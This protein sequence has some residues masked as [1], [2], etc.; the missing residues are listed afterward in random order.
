MKTNLGAISYQDRENSFI[1][2]AQIDEPYGPGSDSVISIGCTLKGDIEN[3]S[4]K[5]HVPKYMISELIEILSTC[6]V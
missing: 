2:I 6:K 3:P 5:V 1:T 4:W